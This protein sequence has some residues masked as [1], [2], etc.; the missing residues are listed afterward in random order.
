MRRWRQ[1]LS[2]GLGL[3]LLLGSTPAAA[4]GSAGIGVTGLTTGLG[5]LAALWAVFGTR[6]A[7]VGASGLAAVAIT[8]L[9][10]ASAVWAWRRQQARV[11][12][13]ALRA[14]P[15]SV[16]ARR[17]RLAIPAGLDGE[18][19]L[20]AVRGGFVRLQAAWDAADVATLKTLTTPEMLEELLHV[21]SVREAGASRTDV[22][23]LHAELLGL[24]E[25]GAAY[26]ASVEFSGLIR[27]SAEQGAV[28]FRELWM[29]ACT[30]DGTPAW[31]LARQQ[32]LL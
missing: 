27:E 3:P 20:D 26:L 30:K 5:L 13:A 10:L 1:G 31:R 17:S 23:S 15:R 18:Q 32:A 11:A 28:P 9:I 6:G 19:V 12:G 7:P 14:V 16:F 8:V 2:L 22:I 29:L 24:E 4:A 21:L 25:L